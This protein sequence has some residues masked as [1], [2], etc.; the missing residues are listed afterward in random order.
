MITPNSGIAPF[1][2]PN[3]NTFTV[4]DAFFDGT[5]VQFIDGR[6][7]R[8]LLAPRAAM[9]GEGC[10]GCARA[11]PL[12]PTDE[13]SRAARRAGWKRGGTGAMVEICNCA[14]FIAR[15]SSMHASP[16]HASLACHPRNHDS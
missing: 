12:R 11:L 8:F 5:S 9:A 6:Q 1:L 16:M 15:S 14:R 2:A 4:P 10:G 3:G 7:T 13:R